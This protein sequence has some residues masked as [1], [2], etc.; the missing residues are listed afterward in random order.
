VISRGLF[1]LEAFEKPGVLV[2]IKAREIL[3]PKHISHIRGFQNFDNAGIG[4]KSGFAKVS[5]NRSD[6]RI[7]PPFQIL[8]F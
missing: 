1:F 8:T 7:C 4:K 5:F 3:K 2:K 6:L